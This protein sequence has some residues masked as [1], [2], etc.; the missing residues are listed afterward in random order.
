MLDKI[1]SFSAKYNMF[2]DNKNVVCGFSGG[3]DSTALLLS[4]YELSEKLGINVS[5]LHVNHCLRGEESDRDENFCRELC[6][7][8]GIPFKAVSCDVRAYA[9][10]HS[11]SDEEAARILR[12]RIFAENSQNS[13]I[14]TAHN[15][16][17]ALETS[18]L[19]II[20]GSGLK[21][22]AG[23]PPV[24]G[25]IIR[26]MLTVTRAEIEHYLSGMLQDFVTDSTNLTEDFTRNKIRRRIIPLMQ[27][28]N[29]SVIETS[30]K[31]I[32][33]L[34]EEN[35]L[36]ESLTDDAFMK[37]RNGNALN[38][39]AEFHPVIR[40]RCIARLLTESSLPYSS[41]RLE[42]ADRI[43]MNGGKLNISGKIFLI[44]SGSTLTLQ[45][46]NAK[47]PFHELSKPLIIGENS[48]FP[49]KIL[50]CS[51]VNCDDLKKIDDVHKKL[52]FYHLDYD[53]IIGRAVVRNRRFGDKIQLPGRNFSS[54]VKKLINESVPPD[55]R[56]T[57][58]FIEDEMGTIFAEHI[59]IAARVSPDPSTGRYLIVSVRNKI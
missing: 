25:N 43:L 49:D 8:Y 36:I 3:A 24:R 29:P 13:L 17:D 6:K 32:E 30:V 26:P 38:G 52:T 37:C 53:K 22:I 15:A 56:D 1:C 27:E 16:G 34:R 19:N 7:K 23:I 4:L 48:L 42:T 41:E 57:M 39:L 45:E 21:G 14:A 54:S 50:D 51:I 5:A 40:K 35:S 59:G 33:T 10:E 58:H 2:A 18:L 9:E 11:L 28:I 47:A 20:R 55:M 12:Y 44:G 46:I 31:S